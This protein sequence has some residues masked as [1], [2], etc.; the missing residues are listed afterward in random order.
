MYFYEVIEKCD[1]ELVVREFLTF[2]DNAPD[3]KATEQAIRNAIMTLDR[4]EP[5]ISNTGILYAARV[6][7]EEYDAVHLFDTAEDEVYGVEANPWAETIGYIVDE[8][9]L[10]V[11]GNEKFAALVLWEM[12]WF[13][14]DEETIQEE[15]NSWEC[16]E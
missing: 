8:K 13:G 3:I 11:Y 14:Y 16:D 12:T 9:S 10:S 6:E 5:V 15:I 7:D 1:L 2:C 4:M